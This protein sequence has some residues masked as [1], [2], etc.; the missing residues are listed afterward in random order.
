MNSL[1]GF[2]YVLFRLVFLLS[3]LVA[4]ASLWFP[5]ARPGSTEPSLEDQN[6]LRRA[7]S[8][9]DLNR[10]AVT[11]RILPAPPV[12]GKGAFKWPLRH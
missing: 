11:R 10:P 6:A 2:T 1:V 9:S 4:C 3:S 12:N 8:L 7:C 5:V